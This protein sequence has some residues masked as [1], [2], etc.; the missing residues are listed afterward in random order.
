MASFEDFAP[1][2]IDAVGEKKDSECACVL[3]IPCFRIKG[4]PVIPRSPGLWPPLKVMRASGHRCR[5]AAL[6]VHTSV[7][8]L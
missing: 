1:Y 6:P 3:F 8:L 7:D 2:T 4:E 5:F